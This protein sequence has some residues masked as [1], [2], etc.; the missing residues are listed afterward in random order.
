[1]EDIIII[2]LLEEA[3]IQELLKFEIE[4]R[5]FIERMF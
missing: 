3:D 1:M 5:A 2:K 4:N